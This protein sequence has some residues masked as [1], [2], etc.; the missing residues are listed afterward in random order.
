MPV[1]S[2]TV[3]VYAGAHPGDWRLY[4]RDAQHTSRSPFT[5]PAMPRQEWVYNLGPRTILGIRFAPV[6][7]TDG[8]GH[9]TH[10]VVG[11][12][13]LTTEYGMHFHDLFL[14]F[15]ARLHILVRD[16]RGDAEGREGCLDL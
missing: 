5:G 9:T 10:E 11:V 16:E 4:L 15:E 1:A 13:I 6:I 8:T 3:F 7:G 14:P 12:R 2:N